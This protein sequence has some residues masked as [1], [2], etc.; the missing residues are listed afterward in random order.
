M[1]IALNFKKLDYLQM[2][3]PSKLVAV[4]KKKKIPTEIIKPIVKKRQETNYW[5]TGFYL[6]EKN[7]VLRSQQKNSKVVDHKEIDQIFL[8]VQNKLCF[9][10]PSTKSNI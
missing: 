1:M 4:I 3:A 5:F 8:K 9:Y 7:I 2:L 10:P 6:E